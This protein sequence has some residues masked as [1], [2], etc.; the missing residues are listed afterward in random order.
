MAR[1]LVNGLQAR[2][3]DVVTTLGAGLGGEDDEVLLE[4]ASRQGLALFTFNVGDFCRLHA[5]WL[6]EGREHSGVV[7][8][9]RQRL[10]IGEQVRGLAQLTSELSAED[11]A[12]Q[13]IFL[14]A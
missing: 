9:P 12:G 1:A 2:G 6:R 3:I 4:Y 13:L 11:L 10:A 8:V 5:D 14:K 7:V